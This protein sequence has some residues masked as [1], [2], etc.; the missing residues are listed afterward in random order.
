MKLTVARNMKG[1]LKSG[2]FEVSGLDLPRQS[3]PV[4][5]EF[6]I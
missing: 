4:M 5:L 1:L 3:L 2:F 6:A